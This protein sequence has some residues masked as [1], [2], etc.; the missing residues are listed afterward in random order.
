MFLSVFIILSFNDQSHSLSNFSTTIFEITLTMA[1]I[2]CVPR[3][4]TVFMPGIWIPGC[5]LPQ[6]L[7]AAVEV[8]ILIQRFIRRKLTRIHAD[9]MHKEAKL[10]KE[11]GIEGSHHES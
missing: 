3:Y 2:L 9:K 11:G 4:L 10:R 1:N 8:A 5:C 6:V 7:F